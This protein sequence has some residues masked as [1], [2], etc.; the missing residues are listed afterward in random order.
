ME[1]AFVSTA[2]GTEAGIVSTVYDRIRVKDHKTGDTIKVTYLE[3]HPALPIPVVLGSIIELPPVLEEAL[4]AR[5][6]S[7]I[8]ESMDGEGQMVRAVGLR[9]RYEEIL[10]GCKE[11]M[12][13]GYRELS[14]KAKLGMKGFR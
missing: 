2:V 10:N 1:Y 6:A 11:L 13:S 3:D 9:G 4:Q 12:V 8:Y 14:D 7:Y 5:V